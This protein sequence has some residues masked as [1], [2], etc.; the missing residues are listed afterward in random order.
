MRGIKRSSI[1]RLGKREKNQGSVL[2]CG[3]AKHKTHVAVLL[4]MLLSIIDSS[5]FNGIVQLARSIMHAGYRATSIGI[6]V[7]KKRKKKEKQGGFALT[8]RI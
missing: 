3:G 7:K 8:L 2:G 6:L 1:T 5:A 4:R